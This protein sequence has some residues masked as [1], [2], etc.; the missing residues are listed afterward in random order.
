MSPFQTKLG[1]IQLH[2]QATNEITSYCKVVP[3]SGSLHG[4]QSSEFGWFMSHPGQ[5]SKKVFVVLGIAGLYL[6][7]FL[8]LLSE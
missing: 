3:N 1:A 4:S 7:F 8:T 6:S 2:V 5:L